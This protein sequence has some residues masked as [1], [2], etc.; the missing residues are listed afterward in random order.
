MEEHC[1]QSQRTSKKSGDLYDG[2]RPNFYNKQFLKIKKKSENI[3]S[4]Q[5]P[6]HSSQ[7][8]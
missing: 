1:R 5:N 6:L 4:E 3:Y 7:K 2:Q 8:Q